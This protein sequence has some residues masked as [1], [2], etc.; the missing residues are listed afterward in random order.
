MQAI[1]TVF[2]HGA[3]F[4]FGVV[5]RV[6][7]KHIDLPPGDN[8]WNSPPWLMSEMV[9][10]GA[11]FVSLEDENHHPDPMD[12]DYM[13]Y[14]VQLR[15]QVD[16][17]N[18]KRFLVWYGKNANLVKTVPINIFTLFFKWLKDILTY[19]GDDMDL[20]DD[21]RIHVKLDDNRGKL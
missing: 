9:D 2:D 6:H 5:Y 4:K 11:D 21:M 10:A 8:S 15:A 16:S 17:K 20:G 14:S 18:M 3:D 7:Y 1:T 13:V 19:R 12:Q